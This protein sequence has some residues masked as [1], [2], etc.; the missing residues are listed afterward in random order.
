MAIRTNQE[1]LTI[2]YNL[3]GNNSCIKG[4]LVAEKDT[5]IEDKNRSTE[6]LTK[7]SE[8][9]NELN[10]NQKAVEVGPDET[11]MWIEEFEKNADLQRFFGL[12]EVEFDNSAMREKLL[13]ISDVESLKN[14]ICDDIL[15][16]TEK[17]E[18]LRKHI[19]DN[20]IKAEELEEQIADYE[21]ASHE[22]GRI[23]SDVLGGAETYTRNYIGDILRKI[24]S[25]SKTYALSES[26]IAVA[27]KLIL[28][29]EEELKQFNDQVLQG[30]I[31]TDQVTEAIEEEEV[32]EEPEP[33][34]EPASP[35]V[36]ESKNVGI[37]ADQI[38]SVKEDT[39]QP[40]ELTPKAEIISENVQE[41]NPFVTFEEAKKIAEEDEETKEDVVENVAEEKNEEKEEDLTKPSAQDIY[42]SEN[43]DIIP[44]VEVDEEKKDEISDEEFFAN[45]GLDPNNFTQKEQAIKILKNCDEEVIKR[46]LEELKALGTSEENIYFIKDSYVLLADKELPSKINLFRSK[47]IK[48]ETIKDIIL[49]T[50]SI[51][52]LP[53]EQMQANITMIEKKNGKVDNSNYLLI[54]NPA[55]YYSSIEDA[56]KYD[57][58]FDEKQSKYIEPSLIQPNQNSIGVNEVLKEYG[59]SAGRRNGKNE[60]DIYFKTPIELENSIDSLIEIGAEE[61]LR[62]TPEIMSVETNPVLKKI[63]Y[64]TDKG[65][66]Y[67]DDS[68]YC[69]KV[70]YIPA[71]FQ[72]VYK[73]VT[74]PEIPSREDNN[75]NLAK[76]GAKYN[77]IISILIE[78]LNGYYANNADSYKTIAIAN[79]EVQARALEIKNTLESDSSLEIVD[80]NTYKFQDEYFS[81]NK[82][83]RN[84]YYLI[85]SLTDKEEKVEDLNKE[86]TIVSLLYNSQKD[87]S[88]IIKLMNQFLGLNI[89]EEMGGPTL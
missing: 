31:N 75:E 34:I 88:V 5:L 21:R 1:L 2:L 29:P 60:I 13:N 61:V 35:L 30:K 48:E 73:D 11:R 53:L 45:L 9:L 32:K 57:I 50:S 26:E 20:G 86:L 46:N 58:T 44:I 22:L 19:E 25:F 59:I 56:A 55:A 67:V 69:K 27:S 12:M 70:V 14:H 39:T 52:S 49:I 68:G 84:L 36:E 62:T 47:G 6:E 72:E 71:E 7:E 37:F 87:A 43:T 83:E 63:K 80:K 65:E 66:S 17:I 78:S 41:E 51:I 24:S 77:D 18:S 64:L 38:P 81:K 76:E 3:I 23:I 8:S 54:S 33:V 28:F 40:T 82:F 42:G 4:E 74:L 15:K 85:T 16:T 10:L 79:P 89:A